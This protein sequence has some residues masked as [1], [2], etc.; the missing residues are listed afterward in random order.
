[1]SPD[2]ATPPTPV[3]VSGRCKRWERTRSVHHHR[4]HAPADLERQ[5]RAAGLGPLGVYGS[6]VT[7]E[8]ERGVDEARHV[9][10]VVIARG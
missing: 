5:L 3:R 10:A 7:G 9:K 4:H 2:S 6:Q 8:L 1:M